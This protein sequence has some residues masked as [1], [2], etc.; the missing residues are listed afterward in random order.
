MNSL[1]K[2]EAAEHGPLAELDLSGFQEALQD[3]YVDLVARCNPLL[4]FLDVRFE[5][6]RC[7]SLF[8]PLF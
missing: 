4:Q 5:S 7:F 3:T 1:C 8:K 6:E 2:V